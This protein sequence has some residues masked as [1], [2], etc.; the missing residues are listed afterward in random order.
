MTIYEGGRGLAG[1][2]VTVDGAPLDPR[3]EVKTFS[4]M[5]YEWTYEGDG[6][7]QLALALLCDHLGDPQRALALV[8]DFMRDVV[9]ELDNAWLLTTEDIAEALLRLQPKGAHT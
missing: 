8:E 9:A 7:R 6:P 5:G 1:A 3:F 2:E 4:P